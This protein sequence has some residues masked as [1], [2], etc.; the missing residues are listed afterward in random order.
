MFAT[1]DGLLRQADGLTQDG[2]KEIFATN[3]FGHFILVSA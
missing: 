1:G 3:V 2:L